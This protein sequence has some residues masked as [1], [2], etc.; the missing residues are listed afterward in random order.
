MLKI[1]YLKMQDRFPTGKYWKCVFVA[2]IK[3]QPLLFRYAFF[4]QMQGLR[5]VIY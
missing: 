2:I 1:R 5:I 3:L 4:F